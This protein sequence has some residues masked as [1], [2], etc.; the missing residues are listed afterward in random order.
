MLC[1]V[2]FKGT[3][4]WTAKHICSVHTRSLRCQDHVDGRCR[5]V[6]CRIGC[7]GEGVQENYAVPDFGSGGEHQCNGAV[8]R[9][10]GTVA[11][12][13]LTL[14]DHI[15]ANVG[16]QVNHR[17][18]LLQW[19]IM[20]PANLFTRYTVEEYGRTLCEMIKGIRCLLEMEFLLGA[21]VVWV[22]VSGVGPVTPRD[23]KEFS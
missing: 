4:E 14:R 8:E 5:R 22:S 23:H 10:V 15:E 11:T 3:Y 13:F 19:L 20:G 2:E 1:A 21:L 12:Q 6:H 18:S 16:A 7:G 9:C 17:N